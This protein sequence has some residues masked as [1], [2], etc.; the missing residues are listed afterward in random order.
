MT[1]DEIALSLGFCL[2][3]ARIM[4]RMDILR[5][6][7][8]IY[9]HTRERCSTMARERGVAWPAVLR[10]EQRNVASDSVVRRES[11]PFWP[12]VAHPDLLVREV[13][14]S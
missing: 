14:E 7:N 8:D 3:R 4:S 2:I 6:D 5:S 9:W 11:E 10:A 13:M 1:D 12:D